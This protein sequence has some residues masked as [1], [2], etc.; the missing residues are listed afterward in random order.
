M[1]PGAQGGAGGDAP[2]RVSNPVDPSAGT[3]RSRPCATSVGGP[4]NLLVRVAKRQEEAAR[5]PK[6]LTGP[7]RLQR[8][9]TSSCGCATRTHFASGP[10]L[11]GSVRE[12]R[13][14]SLEAT[15]RWS[16]V[17][18]RWCVTCGKASGCGMTWIASGP[19]AVTH[20][21][22]WRLAESD[23]RSRPVRAHRVGMLALQGR[24]VC[25]TVFTLA[26]KPPVAPSECV[27]A[28]CRLRLT[29]NR[30][31]PIACECWDES[32][33]TPRRASDPG[34]QDSSLKTHRSPLSRSA[35]AVPG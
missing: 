23:G 34:L 6:H 20:P 24:H 18:C 28:S 3:S 19:S 21:T 27:S 4:D 17:T 10:P 26:G 32:Q 11:E 29:S 15:H 2:A 35:P 12:R 5:T 8:P 1:S 16:R 22:C 13:V 33:P 31:Y 14:A 9:H 25:R 7:E 30:G